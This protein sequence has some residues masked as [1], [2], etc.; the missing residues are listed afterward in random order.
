VTLVLFLWLRIG[1]GFCEHVNEPSESLV[2]AQVEAS[3]E[4][5][6]SMEFVT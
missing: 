5:L 4:G 1:T 3:G 6:S 2:A